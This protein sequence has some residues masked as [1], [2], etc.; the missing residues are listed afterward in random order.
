MDVAILGGAGLTGHELLKILSH[1]PDLNASICTSDRY[2][3][4]PVAGV[5]PDLDGIYD[6]SFQSHEEALPP[7]IPVFLAV[8]N[9]TALAAVPELL[10]KGHPVVDLSGAFRIHNREVFESFYKLKHTAWESMDQMVYGMPEIFRDRIS[11]SSGVANPGCYATGAILPLFFLKEHRSSIEFAAIDGKSGVS[12]AGGRVEDAGFSYNSVYENFRAYKVLKHQHQPE[13]S[14]YASSL[15]DGTV[16]LVFTPHLLPVYRGILTTIVV[17]WKKD[18]P[19]DIVEILKENSSLEPFVR[20]YETPEEVELRKV[21]NTNFID[22]SA[23]SEGRVSVI[24]SAID[25]LQKGAAGQAIQNMNLMLGI[26]E[27][28][29]M[30]L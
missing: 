11:Q 15:I 28:T 5:F 16:S 3:G 17:Y 12:G 23:R 18:A 27:Q 19:P 9:D 10:K 7:K 6:L 29:G 22:I 20:I 4:K 25:N 21:Q 30:I 26:P 14:E 24:V 2:A 13:I 1:H 8:P